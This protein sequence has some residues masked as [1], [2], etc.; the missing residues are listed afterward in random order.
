MLEN[1]YR[2]FD[3]ADDRTEHLTA[4]LQLA[5]GQSRAVPATQH[6]SG[7]QNGMIAGQGM[8]AADLKSVVK[9]DFLA[10]S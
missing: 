3:G 6:G 8:G 2:N 5:A 4:S 7:S 10:G 9:S 1:P